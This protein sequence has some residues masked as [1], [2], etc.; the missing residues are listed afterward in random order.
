MRKAIDMLGQTWGRLTVIEKAESEVQGNS[1]IAKWKCVCECGNE[2]TVR[3]SSL[4]T[5]H[6]KSCGCY[7]R[8]LTAQ[9]GRNNR[10]HGLSH[11]KEY[12]SYKATKRKKR[13]KRQTPLWAD[14]EK[15]RQIYID[16]PDGY[17][18]DHIIPLKGELVC[19]LHVESNLQ[20]LP[21]KENIS[22]KNKFKESDLCHTLM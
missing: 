8:E 22:K 11:T 16:R 15:I 21:A 3:G 9:R 6:I 14:A 18:V 2:T 19:G 5:G 1:T 13:L 20:Y 7:S 10:T 12:K 17:H 4:R